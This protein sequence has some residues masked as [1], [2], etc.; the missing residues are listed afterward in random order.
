MLSSARRFARRPVRA[1]AAAAT[2]TVLAALVSAPA[3]HADA[4]AT[5]PNL[6]NLATNPGFEIPT[7]P[8][9]DWGSIPGWHCAPGEGAVT[10]AARTGAS[11]L[12]VTPAA[13]DSNAQCTQTLAVRPGT[14]YT[15]RAWVHGSYAFLGATGTGH[16]VAPAWTPSTGAG[17]Q[18]LSTTFTTGPSTSSVQLYVHGWYGQGPIGVDDVEVTGDSPAPAHATW[19]AP[20]EDKVVFITIDDGWTRTSE[21]AQLIADQQVP[22]TAF[23]LPMPEGFE[24]DYFSRVTA[25]PGSAV[26][27]HSVSHRDLTTLPPAEQQAEICDARDAVT[28]RYGT[29]PTLFRPPYFAWNADTQQAAANCGMR[30]LVT[31]TADFG[32]GASTVY[33]GGAL[34]PGD[35][36]ILHFTDTLASDLKRALDAARAAGLTPA[37]LGDYLR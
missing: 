37:A 21:A 17:W 16:D 8:L 15:Y 23:P 12:T 20:T 29:T 27:D 35:I 14:T 3:A 30:Y 2:A 9:A 6:P 31:A 36:I 7:L 18:Q 10:A 11:A 1:L 19:N 24:P 33:R 25:A 4:P 26:Q 32:W 13:P 34:Q 22:V 28:A 5:A